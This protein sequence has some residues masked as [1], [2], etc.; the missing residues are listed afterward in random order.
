MHVALGDLAALHDVGRPTT[1]E[2]TALQRQ[3][4]LMAKAS[5][6]PAVQIPGS[7]L[8]PATIR[9]WLSTSVVSRMPASAIARSAARK[10]LVHRR[11][12]LT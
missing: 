10:R 3:P 11:T 6:E 12:E 2:A 5:T 1:A 9:A 8:C 7:V 4:P